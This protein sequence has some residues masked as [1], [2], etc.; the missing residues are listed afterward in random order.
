MFLGTRF[1][2]RKIASQGIQHNNYYDVKN[3]FS[4]PLILLQSTSFA[5]YNF[6]DGYNFSS[7]YLI[8][9]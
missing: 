7:S 3:G 4:L 8:K 6:I 1:L 9:L 2:I 5:N